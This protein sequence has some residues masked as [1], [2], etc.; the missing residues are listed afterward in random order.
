MV[1]DDFRNQLELMIKQELSRAIIGNSWWGNI[2]DCIRSFAADY[3][4]RLKIDMVA[5]QSLI[6]A[7]LDRV[8]LAGDSVQVNIAGLLAS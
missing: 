4:R 1:E 7:K 3:S 6:K 5:E 2:K 8:V